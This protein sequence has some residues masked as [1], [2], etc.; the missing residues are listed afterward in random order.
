LPLLDV[1]DLAG[2]RRRQQQV[3]LTAQEG[4][5]LQHV[6]RLRHLGALG[7]L[8]HVGPEQA[9]PARERISAKIGSAWGEPDAARGGAAGPVGLVE[10]GLVDEAYSEPGPRSLSVRPPPPAQCARLSSWHGPAMIEI[11]RSLPNLTPDLPWPTVDD[12]SCSEVRVQG[13]FLL[14]ARTMP[15]RANP[16]SAKVGTGFATR[17]RAKSESPSIFLTENALGSTP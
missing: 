8:V 4:R 16:Y 14:P 1:D 3:G 7:G 9:V 15:V 17:I 5:D 12:G 6:H 11:G 10:R 13:I 2:R